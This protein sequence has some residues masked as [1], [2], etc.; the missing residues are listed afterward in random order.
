MDFKDTPPELLPVAEHVR[1]AQ[2]LRSIY[3]AELIGS[4]V[5]RVA[6]AMHRLAQPF[7]V[8]VAS[9][10]D[11]RAVEADPFLRRAVARY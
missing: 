10:E 6:G 8:G 5:A 11:R 2:A 1:R 9:E 3:L 7:H 4:A